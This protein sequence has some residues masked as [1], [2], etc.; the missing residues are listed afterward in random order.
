MRMCLLKKY[1]STVAI[2]VAACAFV[3]L[4]VA[5]ASAQEPS[6]SSLENGVFQLY[7]VRGEAHHCQTVEELSSAMISLLLQEKEQWK[8]ESGHHR[9]LELD[10]PPYQDMY[11]FCWL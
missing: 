7:G 8:N 9:E 5:P 10:C 11:P 6:S 4:L 2:L 1:R 3:L